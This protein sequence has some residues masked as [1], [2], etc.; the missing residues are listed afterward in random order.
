MSINREDKFIIPL[1]EVAINGKFADGW[2]LEDEEER[3]VDIEFEDEED[4]EME[5][6]DGLTV[7]QSDLYEMFEALAEHYGKFTQG[8]G[9]DG[10]AYKPMSPY[11]EQGIACAQCVFYGGGGNCEIVEGKISPMGLCRYWIISADNIGDVE[12]SMIDDE[13]IEVEPEE[14]AVS[15]EPPVYMRNAA[16]R[17]LKMLEEGHGGDGLMPQTVEDARKMVR[18]EVSEGKWRK[19]GPWIARHLV[20]L[21]AS[22]NN[23]PNDKGYPGAGLVAHL[24]W[25]SG[26]S[27]SDAVRAQEYAEGVVS[28]IEKE[29]EG[30]AASQPAP[31]SDQIKGSTENP[32]GS[33][34]G[35]SGGITLNASIEKGLSNKVSEHNKAMDE[36]DRPSWTKVTLGALKAVYRRGAGAYSTS[37]RPGVSRG[38]WAMARVNAFL[39]LSKNGR[40]KN[41]KYVTDNDLLKQGHPKYSKG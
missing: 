36:A 21:D 9:P 27:K 39:F 35:K 7:R 40:P 23:N 34:Q 1:D 11:A 41:P 2:T 22:K 26:P 8:I 20:D 28:R 13:G 30:R 32:A 17:G 38:A 4:E 14:R 25:G 37:H 5:E 12:E 29:G 3:S 16:R 31:K 6:D 18:G 33:A 10:C 15:L 19:I 24:L